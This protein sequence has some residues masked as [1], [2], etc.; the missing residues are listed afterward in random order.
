MWWMHVARWKCP[1]ILNYHVTVIPECLTIFFSISHHNLS[2]FLIFNLP[3][4]SPKKILVSKRKRM[5]KGKS[6]K[7]TTP[8]LYTGQPTLFLYYVMSKICEQ[9]I[10]L[11][12]AVDEAEYLKYDHCYPISWYNLTPFFYL[13]SISHPNHTHTHTHTTEKG[14]HSQNPRNK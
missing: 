12:G 4:P 10:Q 5:R 2:Q 11:V 6:V 9:R 1:T 7:S 13:I 3:S 8:L 14:P